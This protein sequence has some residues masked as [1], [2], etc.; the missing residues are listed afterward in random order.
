[1]TCPDIRKYPR[2]LQNPADGC[3]HREML[4]ELEIL[5]FDLNPV[6]VSTT[7]AT[8]ARIRVAPRAL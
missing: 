5:E 6:M 1:M 2:G 8:A 3:L 4:D 7:G